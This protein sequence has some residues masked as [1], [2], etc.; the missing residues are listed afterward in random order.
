[1]E[2]LW[3]PWRMGYI[4]QPDKEEG[5]CFLCHAAMSGQDRERHVLWRGAHTF[6]VLNRW[7]YN[8]G[9]LMVAPLEHKPDLAG[10]SD[11][12]LLEQVQ[13]LRRCRQRLGR[14]LR[15]GGF[16]IGLNLGEAAGAGLAGH[17]HWH[18]VPR[19]NGD[20][21]FMPALADT[22]V[23]PQS[24]DCLWELLQGPDEV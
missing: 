11:E 12:E 8:N 6:C 5:G 24:L 16:N 18:I 17:L 23:I 3:A 15:P 20:T 4:S 7:P 10:M 21:N 2:Q 9:H 14:L 1:M 13:M 22:K 19:W